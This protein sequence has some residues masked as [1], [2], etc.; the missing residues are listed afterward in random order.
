MAKPR[1]FS[2]AKDAGKGD[3]AVRLGPNPLAEGVD[4]LVWI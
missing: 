2:N 4:G 1:L 3:G